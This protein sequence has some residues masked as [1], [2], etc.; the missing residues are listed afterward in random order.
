MRKYLIDET[1]V[2]G[3]YDILEDGVFIASAYK[4]DVACRICSAL[5][6]YI[7]PPT[8]QHDIAKPDC[9]VFIAYPTAEKPSI[10][11]FVCGAVK[12]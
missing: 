12:M 11:C 8:C 1:K 5:E 6:S 9:T 3:R 2:K 10:K 7:P 4:V